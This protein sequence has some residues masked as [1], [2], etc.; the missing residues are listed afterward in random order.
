M[1]NLRSPRRS[2]RLCWLVLLVCG[3]LSG[4]T[5]ALE[6]AYPLAP[7]TDVFVPSV[8][9]ASPGPALLVTSTAA[10]QA[11]IDAA[12]PGQTIALADGSYL[13]ATLYLRRSGI[14]VQAQTPGGVHLNGAQHIFVTGNGNVLRGFQFN[15]G[16][17]GEDTVIDV[18]GSDNVLSQ[19][20]FS[21]YRARR[22]VHFDAGS[23]RN[24]LSYSAIS[25]KSAAPIGPAIQ[26][27]TS[28]TSPGYHRIRYC[29]F[30]LFPGP[31]GDH[32]NEPIRIGLG[33][34][35]AN[36]SRT[37]VEHCYFSGVGSGDSE[38]ISVKSSEN[39]CRYNT[40]TNNPGGMMVFR[41][42]N[43]N[44]A[45]GNFFL[46]SSGGVRVKEG[47]GHNIV[48]NYF[49]TGA[50]DAFA[51]DFV[52]SDPAHD[53]RLVHNTFANMGAIDL[54]G[55]GPAGMVFANNLFDKAA[56]A[57]F[58]DDN[59]KTSFFGNLNRGSLGIA[60]ASGMTLVDPLLERN[61]DGYL[62]PGANS[63]AVDSA[64]P[65]LPAL[66]DVQGLDTDSAVNFDIS[67]Q[68][69]PEAKAQRDVGCSERQTSPSATRLRP[70][71]LTDVGPVYLGGPAL[72]PT[73]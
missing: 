4:C 10:L 28:P 23:H 44:T 33:A 58:S 32:G 37:L 18:T 2:A 7:S 51:V 9:P 25:R 71:L 70:L 54:G 29:A 12:S 65:Q 35:R 47:H 50:D 20:N 31:G 73:K 66:L 8:W 3:A 45:Y 16:D 40:F 24:E 39:V 26:I 63:P 1:N 57:I 69:R 53:I 36:A 59:G 60:I 21:G 49:E 68:P 11:A 38:S 6:D 52:A 30:R 55:P 13:D 22:Y 46:A 56:G 34:E 15:S 17:I 43:H 64:N 27:N 48:N 62:A 72:A 42:G 61:A 67:G 41:A 14:T 5:A 19:I